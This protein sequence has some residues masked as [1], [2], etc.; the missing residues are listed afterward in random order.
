MSQIIPI[1]QWGEV[2]LLLHGDPIPPS[3]AAVDF[4]WCDD[5]RCWPVVL[6]TTATG[7]SFAYVAVAPPDRPPHSS[8]S[9][10]IDDLDGFVLTEPSL[11]LRCFA[12]EHTFAGLYPDSGVPFFGNHLSRHRLVATCPA[13]GA[14]FAH[15]R[16]SALHI[17]KR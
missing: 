15:S 10:S 11:S 5:E 13:C 3:L 14:D 12:C 4:L 8:A 1:G 9:W 17:M 16:L 6:T 2:E 7:S